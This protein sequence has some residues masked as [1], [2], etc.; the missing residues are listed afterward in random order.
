MNSKKAP[1]FLTRLLRWFC[2]NDLLEELLGD[3]EETFNNNYKQ[4]GSRRAKWVYSIEVLKLFRPSVIRRPQKVSLSGALFSNYVIISIRNLKRHALFS[5]INI[6]SLSIAMSSGLLVIGMITDLLKFD[7][8]HEHKN[9]VYRVIS[10]PTFRGNETKPQATSPFFL[11]EELI[12]DIQEVQLT[13]L[14]RRLAGLAEVNE[15]NI[16]TKG[17]YADEHFFDF[18]TFHLLKGNPKEALKEPYSLVISE[19]FA[20]KTFEDLDPIGKTLSLKDVGSFIITG[21]VADPPMFSHLQFDFIASISTT[22]LLAK[23]GV[24]HPSHNA[25]ENLDMYYNYIYLPENADKQAVEDWL[26]AKGPTYYKDREY[27]TSTFELQPLNEIVPGPNISD[28]IGPKMIYLPVIILS[29]IATAILLS[30]IFNY[31]NLSMARSLGRARE[32]G[33]RKLSGAKKRSILAQFAIEASVFS[34]LSLGFGLLLFVIL[35]DYFIKLL[36]RA[37]EMVEL[38]LT[39]ELLGYFVVYAL[40]TGIIAGLGPSFF[41]SRL[42]SLNALRSGKNLK[43]LSRISLRKVL[44]AA[45]FTLSIIFILAVVITNEQYSYALNMDMGFNRGNTL[46]V[47]LRGNNHELLR[48]EFLKHPEVSAVSFSSFTL[49]LGQW[50]NL[51]IVDQRNMDT[52]WVHQLSTDHF[53]LDQMEI[54]LLAGRNFDQE[55]NT[56]LETTILVNETF[57]RNFGYVDVSDAIGQRIDL[58]GQSVEIIGVVKDFIYANLEETIRSL[59][60]RRRNNYQVASVALNSNDIL[61]TIRNLEQTWEK[62]DPKQEFEAKFYDD[63][64]ED[65]YTFLTDFM[66]IFGYVGFLAVSISCL[67]LLGIAI[68]STE[69][70]MKEIGIRK[71]FGASEF[72]LI[73]LLSKGFL[74]IICWA[75]LIGTPIC[76]VLFDQVILAENV[77]RHYITVS[78]IVLSISF[79][80]SISLITVFSQTWSAAR[81][82]P[83]LVLRDE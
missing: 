81:K 43:S 65:Y 3:L 42:S 58:A 75:I 23:K 35:R 16:Y 41:F 79:L 72:S 56:N 70:R 61:N 67:G 51:K 82:S 69:T 33:I 24:L 44:I 30:A 13:N 29:I 11:G 10:Y 64:M 4:L 48:T 19:R 20:T 17:I 8:F 60:I 59:V 7:E 63:Q 54:P 68:Y 9:E 38:R 47:S 62:I 80:L 45:Q 37:E 18:L 27:F 25:W 15:K 50:H 46:N 6:F 74:K 22:P 12:R 28:S 73:Y 32:I 34:L 26:K 1:Q 66:K 52:V 40:F 31:T 14:G 39:P 71:T 2:K 5:F 55:E 83:A 53:Y 57:V 77:Y 36:P 78:E 49:G 76:Y 21:V